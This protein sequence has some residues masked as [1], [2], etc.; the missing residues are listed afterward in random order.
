M[1]RIQIQNDNQQILSRIYTH[2]LADRP[3]GQDF[4]VIGHVPG[5]TNNLW[6][7]TTFSWSSTKKIGSPTMNPWSSANLD[8]IDQ[9][10]LVGRVKV[11]QGSAR[12]TENIGR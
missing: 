5:S 1:R 7:P 8:V 2:G 4:M 10:K 12:A 6:S 9:Q 3:I 11:A